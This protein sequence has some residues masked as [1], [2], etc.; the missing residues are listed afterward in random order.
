MIN[1]EATQAE[2]EEESGI[3]AILYTKPHLI[4]IPINL[5][6]TERDYFCRSYCYEN[7]SFI[8]D[9]YFLLKKNADPD[10]LRKQINA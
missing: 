4:K 1:S 3:N 9:R 2:T 5:T 10:K 6:E 8:F 7:H